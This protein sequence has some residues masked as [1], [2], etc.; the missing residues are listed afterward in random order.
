MG[1]GRRE[2]EGQGDE[3]DAIPKLHNRRLE[4]QELHAD[5]VP[6]FSSQHN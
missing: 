2:E 1:I 4:W 6:Y 5:I 3:K